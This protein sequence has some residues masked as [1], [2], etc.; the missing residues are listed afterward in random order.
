MSDVPILFGTPY[1]Y[2]R[3]QGGAGLNR[4]GPEG[5]LPWKA[6]YGLK[7][8][9]KVFS[10]GVRHRAASTAALTRPGES[11]RLGRQFFDMGQHLFFAGQAHEIEAEHLIGA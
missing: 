1:A 3:P 9:A 7:E 8:E 4:R 6:G 11:V 5:I 10:M 2:G